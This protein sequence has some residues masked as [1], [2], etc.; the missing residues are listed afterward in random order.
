M[1]LTDIAAKGLE[2]LKEAVLH[3]TRI[4]VLW[5]PTTPSHVYVLKAVEAAGS[6]LGGQLLMAPVR[7]V[8][9][10]EAVFAMMAREGPS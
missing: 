6:S 3:A 7:T 10:F 2:I 8:E 5:N 4:G 9:D 1:A